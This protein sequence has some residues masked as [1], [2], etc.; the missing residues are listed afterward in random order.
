MPLVVLPPEL[1]T[2]ELSCVAYTTATLLARPGRASLLARILE[3]CDLDPGDVANWC[4]VDGNTRTRVL[5]D[6]ALTGLSAH[7]RVHL[8]RVGAQRP[9]VAVELRDAQRSAAVAATGRE[10]QNFISAEPRH[11]F[12][13]FLGVCVHARALPAWRP[14]RPAGRHA[15]VQAAPALC[16]TA[17]GVRGCIHG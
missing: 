9:P 14:A 10:V 11:D 6:A 3:E 15:R 8:S 1:A 4:L 2:P 16:R 13:E 12:M 5:S 17:V 7:A